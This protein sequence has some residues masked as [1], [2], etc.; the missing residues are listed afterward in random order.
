MSLGMIVTLFAWMAHK[1]VSSNRPTRYAS[2]ASC[3]GKEQFSKNIQLVSYTK[4]WF[5]FTL[6][7]HC[8]ILR[9]LWMKSTL[10]IKWIIIIIK[11][12]AQTVTQSVRWNSTC[13]KSANGSTLEAEVSLEILGNFS[14]Q[15]LE[16]QF[17]DKQ[18]GGLLIPTDLPQSH[19]PWPS[20]NNKNVSYKKR[21]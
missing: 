13:L 11:C 10:Q 15:S 4:T 8:S 12:L 14:D 20:K 7:N 18:L 9:F 21:K 5:A 6:L 1:L 2:L 16:R 3:K 19:C 17:A